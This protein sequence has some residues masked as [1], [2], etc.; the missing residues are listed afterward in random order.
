MTPRR[1]TPGTGHPY[2]VGTM[3]SD[4]PISRPVLT[5]LIVSGFLLI[6]AALAAVLVPW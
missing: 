6:I 4:P 2:A 5:L 3:D 1:T